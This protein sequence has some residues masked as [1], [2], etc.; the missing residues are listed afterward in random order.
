MDVG[1]RFAIPSLGLQILDSPVA[2]QSYLQMRPD[3]EGRGS[4][5]AT[6]PH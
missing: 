5:S 1:S 6:V 3:F 4:K 2:V